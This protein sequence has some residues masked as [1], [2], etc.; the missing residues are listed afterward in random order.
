MVRI[1]EACGSKTDKNIYLNYR[2]VCKNCH[3]KNRRKNNNN[4]LIQNK[5]HSP[6]EK[7]TRSSHHQRKFRENN[8][9][10]SAY[11]NHRPV[12]NGPSNKGKTCYMLKY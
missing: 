10:V 9:T 8:P 4:T 7:G 1:C 5:Q 2:T 6:S 11:E 12:F 3:N